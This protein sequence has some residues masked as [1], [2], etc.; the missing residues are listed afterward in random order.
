[1]KIII[2]GNRGMLGRDLDSAARKQGHETVGF[3]LPGFDLAGDPAGFAALP[4]ADAVVNCAAFTDVDGAETQA[5]AALA[6]NGRGPGRLAAWCARR[7]IPLLHISTDYV[8]DGADRHPIAEDHPTHPLNVYGASKLAGEQAVLESGCRALVIR[9]QSLYGRH[10]RHFVRAILDRARAGQALRV[11]DDQFSAPT[12][13][14]HLAD[15]ILRL[16]A[17]GKDGIVHVSASGF[18][19]WYEFAC[20]IVEAAGVAASVTAVP[21]SAYPRPAARP[22]YAVLDGSRYRGWT[23]HAMPHWREGLAAYLAE[24][25]ENET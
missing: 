3:D 1:M 7:E 22:A 23:G 10:G 15:A 21:A 20:A 13:T 12:Y 24:E 14:V 17:T 2:I 5:D 16:L 4:A 9:T 8:F 18:C 19:S 6:V 25:R 11:V